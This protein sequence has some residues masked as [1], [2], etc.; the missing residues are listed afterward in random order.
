MGWGAMLE[1]GKHFRL[2]ALMKL[3]KV[4]P[5][6]P[7]KALIPFLL[8]LGTVVCPLV[9]CTDCRQGRQWEP[10]LQLIG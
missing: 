7:S 1:G 10:G 3:T 9:S 2:F 6:G 4:V 8:S 5:A